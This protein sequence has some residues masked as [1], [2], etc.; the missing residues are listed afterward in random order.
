MGSTTNENI[1]LTLLKELSFE[2]LNRYSTKKMN[3]IETDKN[4]RKNPFI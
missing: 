2:T 1:D 3:E 4:I